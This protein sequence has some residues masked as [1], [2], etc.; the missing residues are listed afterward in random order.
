MIKAL[1]FA[2]RTFKLFKYTVYCLLSLNILLFFREEWQATGYLFKDGVSG[3]DIIAGFAAT[4]DTAAWVV[5]LLMFELETFVLPDEK[6]KGRLK[7]GLEST[8][9]VCYTF[10]CYAFYG[11]VTKC[12]GLYDFVPINLADLCAIADGGVS[13]MTTLDEY[14]AVTPQSCSLLSESSQ[15]FALPDAGIVADAETL[16]A[17]RLLAWTDV[18]NAA[19]WLLVVAILEMDVRLQLKGLLKGGILTFSKS[20]KWVLYS[21]LLGAA[22]YWWLEGDFLDFWDAFLWI[23]A[24]AAI[25]LNVFKWQAETEGS[26]VTAA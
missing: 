10:I 15:F 16:R 17:S 20:I 5:L 13:F 21:I 4:I 1:Q 9:V 24:F 14:A 11:Y 23:L 12:I 7:F 2:P 18:I 19:D 26:Q 8:R 6:I 3:S 25:E 22:V